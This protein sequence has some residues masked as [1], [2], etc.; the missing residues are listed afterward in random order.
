MFSP[1]ETAEFLEIYE[2]GN[3]KIVQEYLLEG[4]APLFHTDIKDVPKWEKDN[5]YMQADV[6]RF[7]GETDLLLFRKIEEEN[8][9]LR[10]ELNELK[11]MLEASGQGCFSENQKRVCIFG[12]LL[13]KK[14]E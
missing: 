7:I 8:A 10:R 5:P 9:K 11:D 13:Y 14:S 2:E 3:Q 12:P 1:E 4:D 6:I